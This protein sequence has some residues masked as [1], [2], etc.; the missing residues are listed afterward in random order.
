MNDPKACYVTAEEPPQVLPETTDGS[1]IFE[2]EPDNEDN[3]VN[4]TCGVLKHQRTALAQESQATDENGNV[5]QTS[6]VPGPSKEGAR[7]LPGKK[8]AV[9]TESSQKNVPAKRPP[10]DKNW[11]RR[12]QQILACDLPESHEIQR[13][14]TA[15]TTFA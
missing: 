7:W 2:E 10:E 12:Q 6:D 14:R 1:N 4:P 13:P 3:T 15:P 8:V 9:G 5:C 11:R